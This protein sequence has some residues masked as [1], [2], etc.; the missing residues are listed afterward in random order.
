M[1]CQLE[2]ATNCF[3]LHIL[4]QQLQSQTDESQS[5]ASRERKLRERSEAFSREL[6]QEIEAL[7]QR[8]LGRSPSATSLEISQEVSRYVKIVS[9]TVRHLLFKT[10]CE[11]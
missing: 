1:E 5:E 4:F 7:K 8:Q 6:E 11:I 3:N 2:I 10:M 9:A